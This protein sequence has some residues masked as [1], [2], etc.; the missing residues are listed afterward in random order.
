MVKVRAISSSKN[1]IVIEAKPN[2]LLSI[3]LK[4][5]VTS[6]NW[7]KEKTLIMAK[8]RKKINRIVFTVS[9]FR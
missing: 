7:R 2:Q 1:G 9:L 5:V 3:M 4:E 6:S 8:I